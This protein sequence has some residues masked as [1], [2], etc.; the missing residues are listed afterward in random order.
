MRTEEDAT[1]PEDDAQGTDRISRRAERRERR[2]EGIWKT[3]A[4]EMK[5]RDEHKGELDKQVLELHKAMPVL[6]S[7]GAKV[8]ISDDTIENF[9]RKWKQASEILGKRA[10]HWLIDINAS[11]WRSVRHHCRTLTNSQM[12]DL[13]TCFR[14]VCDF[15]GKTDVMGQSDDADDVR[16]G[17]GSPIASRVQSIP[18]GLGSDAQRLPHLLAAL[19]DE[20][21]QLLCVELPVLFGLA[22]AQIAQVRPQSCFLSTHAVFA[23]YVTKG[24]RRRKRAKTEGETSAPGEKVAPEDAARETQAEAEEANGAKEAN[25]PK[26]LYAAT[27]V[28]YSGHPERRERQLRVGRRLIALFGDRPIGRPGRKFVEAM[29]ERL[30][31]ADRLARDHCGGGEPITFK[32]LNDE[33]FRQVFSERFPVDIER[34]LKVMDRGALQK[35]E[36][37]IRDALLEAYRQTGRVHSNLRDVVPGMTTQESSARWWARELRG[38]FPEAETFGAKECWISW[39]SADRE[40]FIG[41]CFTILAKAARRLSADELGHIAHRAFQ[42]TGAKA[43]AHPW[44]EDSDP[45]SAVRIFQRR[46]AL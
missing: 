41:T 44:Y 27:E 30:K 29:S 18:A 38:L 28:E 35:R 9:A 1:R 36:L 21:W 11:N 16:P 31:A 8:S 43:A 24:K 13:S 26:M 6:R 42:L 12:T 7:Q 40:P 25:E 19:G 20:T 23:P 15:L 3:L 45:D 33:F 46:A 32:R 34:S 4:E 2:Q 14:R 22:P 10:P 37:Q 17:H 39:C 5:A